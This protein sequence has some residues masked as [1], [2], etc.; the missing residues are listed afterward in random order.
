MADP[1]FRHYDPTKPNLAANIPHAK[2]AVHRSFIEE[3]HANGA[4]HV[5][6]LTRF[7]RRGASHFRCR[8]W[9]RP[10]QMEPHSPCLTWRWLYQF[11]QGGV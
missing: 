9:C 8:S 4:T 1:A 3:M 6:M 5:Q 11:T 2:C 7:R 10:R